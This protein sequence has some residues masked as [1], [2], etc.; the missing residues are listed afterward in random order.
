MLTAVVLGL[1]LQ[2]AVVPNVGQT[3]T[4]CPSETSQARL[5]PNDR[6]VTSR[7]LLDRSVQPQ[8][9]RRYLLLDRR[10]Q[11]NCPIPISFPV[12]E[13]HAVGRNLLSPDGAV[14]LPPPQRPE[15]ADPT[16]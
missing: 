3:R 6:A 7:G 9:V 15:T 10:D 1:S 16:L 14:A 12:D 11:N 4:P 2:A 13:S 8:A 5:E